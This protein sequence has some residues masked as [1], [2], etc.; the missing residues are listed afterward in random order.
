MMTLP[1]FDG[2]PQIADR[3]DP[4]ADIIL[5]HGDVGDFV[6]AIPDGWVSLII[7]SPPYNLGKEYEDR[8]SINRYL[9]TQAQVIAELCRILRDDG[10][11]C[12][13]VG[14]FVDEG[15]VYPLDITL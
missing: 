13:Q 11:I 4:E 10:S 2:P 14:N 6:A 5:Y 3:F 8:V 12:W 1:L 15:E 9:D 7:T